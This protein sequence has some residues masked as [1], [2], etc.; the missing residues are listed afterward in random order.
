MYITNGVTSKQDLKLVGTKHKK[1]N[2]LTQKNKQM[3]E[4]NHEEMLSING[5]DKFMSDLGWSIG[6]ILKNT[7]GFISGGSSSGNATLMNCI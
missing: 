5:G 6:S 3:E 1:Q 2:N 7:W 4:L